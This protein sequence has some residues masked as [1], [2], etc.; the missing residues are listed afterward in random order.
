MQNSFCEPYNEFV[1]LF[2]IFPS[3]AEGWLGVSTITRP[4]LLSRASCPAYTES[5]QVTRVCIMSM[6]GWVGGWRL[7][8]R[9]GDLTLTYYRIY[10]DTLIAAVGHARDGSV[11]PAPLAPARLCMCGMSSG[12]L[13]SSSCSCCICVLGENSHMLSGRAATGSSLSAM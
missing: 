8:R 11:S 9:Q 4:P 5:K 13:R 2:R 7:D 3:P 10:A 12:I 6:G 1:S